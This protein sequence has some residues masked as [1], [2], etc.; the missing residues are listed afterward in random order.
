MQLTEKYQP[1]HLDDFIGLE[2]PKA[3]MRQFLARPYESAFLFLGPSGIGKTSFA[4]AVA[5][6]LPG[7]I[8]TIPSQ[9]CDKDAVAAL[10]HKCAYVSMTSRWHVALVEEC[11]EMSHAAQL[12]FLSVLD[13]TLPFKDTVFIFSANATKKLRPRFLSRCRIIEFTTEGIEDAGAQ[14][15]EKI[16]HAETSA[17][18]PPDFRQ[19]MIDAK[20]NIRAALMNLEL[21]I[22]CPSPPRPKYIEPVTIDAPRRSRHDGTVDPKR[23]EACKRAWIT[24]RANRAAKSA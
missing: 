5:R 4:N 23:S 2:R 17:N 15:L 14:F 6:A 20:N 13:G 24:I 18:T 10:R 19:L 9:A 21:E 16:Y 11:D 12:A 1:Q 3:I 7:E 8:H 22:L